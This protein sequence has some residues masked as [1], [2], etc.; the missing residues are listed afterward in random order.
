MKRNG[1]LGMRLQTTGKGHSVRDAVR[2]IPYQD[3]SWL[4]TKRFG[5]YAESLDI[6]S[7]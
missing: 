6:S 2:S 1:A 5:R 3:P 4:Q 7:R